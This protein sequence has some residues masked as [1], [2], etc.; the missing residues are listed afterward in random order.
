[1]LEK[2]IEDLVCEY[3]QFAHG[4][5]AGGWSACFCEVCGDGAR[6]KGPR[7]GW[8]FD[9]EACA[10]HC[11]NCDVTGTF[12][13]DREYPFSRKMVEIFDAFNIPNKEYFAIGYANKVLG[14]G[15]TKKPEK[16]KVVINAI[17]MP[18]YFC[19]LQQCKDT[20]V[21]AQKAIDE[22]KYRNINPDDY[23]FFISTGRSKKGVREEAVA[24]SMMDR[25]IIPFYNDK[26]DLI[27]FQGRALDKSAKKKY[28][29]A[30]IPRTNIIYGMHRLHIDQ[31]KPLYV[32]EGF[33]DA[34]HLNGVSIQ[35]NNLTQGQIDIL[36]RSRRKKVFVPDRKSDSSK[37]IDQCA[38]LGW[39]V[40]IPD[41][42]TSCKDIDDA[43]RRYGKL[44]TLSQVATNIND[45]AKDAKILLK[46]SGYLIK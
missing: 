44:H 32:T 22:L 14:D 30:D 9:G 8:R 17:D 35:E 16:P 23:P 41:I 21:I 31:N 26:G 33:F 15:K 34:Y 20:N 46:L 28:I 6:T 37:V 43:I 40:A 10:Y 7:G 45:D 1:M 3:V 27:Y 36:K 18:D 11:F 4:V 29:N 12:D 25:L 38:E 5:K 2:N 42:G 19:L 13:P 39:S 24:K